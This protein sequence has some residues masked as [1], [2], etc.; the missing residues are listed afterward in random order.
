MLGTTDERPK[1]WKEPISFGS[2][3]N[4]ASATQPKMQH[5]QTLA[6]LQAAERLAPRAQHL[7]PLG[8]ELELLAMEDE[9]EERPADGQ[10]DQ[11]GGEPV[12]EEGEEVEIDADEFAGGAREDEVGRR[13]DERGHPADARGE[14]DAEK[15][16]DLLA[17]GGLVGTEERADRDGDRVH[18]RRGRGVRDPHREEGGREHHARHQP[19][20][21]RAHRTD[22][23]ERDPVMRVPPLECRGE[24]EAAEVEEDDLVGE[25]RCGLAGGGDAEEGKECDRQQGGDGERQALADPPDGHPDGDREDG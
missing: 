8:A 20:R 16:G 18:H 14:G 2:R 7:Q 19:A 21:T 15:E 1:M 17:V 9:D 10:E 25:M 22:H 5:H 12:L 3:K 4:Q 23:A 13:A 11:R 6:P 24:H